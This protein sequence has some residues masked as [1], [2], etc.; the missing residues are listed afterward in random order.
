MTPMG[1]SMDREVRCFRG[2]WHG[3]VDGAELE[4]PQGPEGPRCIGDLL[5]GW[6]SRSDAKGLPSGGLVLRGARS[7]TPDAAEEAK[8]MQPGAPHEGSQRCPRRWA[9]PW[10]GAGGPEAPP[11]ARA[12]PSPQPA[13]L[14]PCPSGSTSCRPARG[15]HMPGEGGLGRTHRM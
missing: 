3:A 7:A 14:R 5:S 15:A 11:V 8:E 13:S 6:G 12:H 10:G 4:G 2:G 1:E 9:T